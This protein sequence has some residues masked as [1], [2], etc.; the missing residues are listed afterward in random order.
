MKPKSSTTNTSLNNSIS[1][2][3]KRKITTTPSSESSSTQP[4]SSE[5]KKALLD[6]LSQRYNKREIDPE[7]DE[8]TFEDQQARNKYHDDDENSAD[9]GV[10]EQNRISMLRS[11]DESLTQGIYKGHTVRKED[12]FDDGD[13]LR[14][15]KEQEDYLEEIKRLQQ[16]Q[17]SD[18]EQEHDDEHD[19]NMDQEDIM[20]QIQDIV[21]EDLNDVTDNV[22]SLKKS[23]NLEKKKATSVLNQKLLYDHLLKIR[24]LLQKP[25]TACNR[26]PQNEHFWDFVETVDDILGSNNTSNESPIEKKEDSNSGEEENGEAI[27][28]KSENL[29][30]PKRVSTLQKDLVHMIADMLSLQSELK[31]KGMIGE[32]SQ[33]IDGLY[34]QD[35]LSNNKEGDVYE[36]IWN[37]L[38]ESNKSIE[39]FRNES[40]ERWATKT[41]IQSNVGGSSSKL[42][43][44][45]I[46]TGIIQQVQNALSNPKEKQKLVDRTH[47]KQF[48]GSVLGKRERDMK[49]HEETGLEVDSEIFDDK[50]FYQVL[51][52]DLIS[53]VGGASLGSEISFRRALS[54]NKTKK[55]QYSGKT[56]GKTIRYTVHNELVNFMAPNLDNEIPESATTL[57]AN[58]FG[59][60]TVEFVDDEEEEE[61]EQTIN[62]NGENGMLT[63]SD[64]AD[65]SE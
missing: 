44:K 1:L 43:L 15:L 13:D 23:R 14:E 16:L 61:N 46:N 40:I 6:K 20:Q 26:F 18:E 64:S 48:E 25:L 29:S 11:L 35:N 9:D 60:D 37:V 7:N 47:L 42:N 12:L 22:E 55:A 31:E 38:N 33:K 10:S 3:K 63:D 8:A 5:K 4:V 56:K 34:L 32:N 36:R 54:K 51:L 17:D 21:D 58:L 28:E 53:E 65:D 2:L 30:I 19:E 39:K 50:D 52:K 24:I 57:F 49:Y 27:P 41:K 62:E 45:V 59:G